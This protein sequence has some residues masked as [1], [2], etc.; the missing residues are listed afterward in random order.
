MADNNANEQKRNIYSFSPF[1]YEGAL[2]TVETDLRRGIPAV[3]IVGLA[4]GAVKEARERV[5][6]AFRN[7]GFEF[8][9]ERVLMSLSPADLKKEGASFDLAMAV[10]ILNEQNNYQGEPVLVLGE[11]E[12]SGNVRPVRAVHAAVESAVAAGITNVIVPAANVEEALAVPGSKVRGVSSLSEA[13]T[14]LKNNE[15]F[16]ETT[17]DNRF[18]KEVVFDEKLIDE[19][20]DVLESKYDG[21]SALDGHYDTA[22]AIE[23]AIAGKHNLLLTGSPGCGKT[24]L[25]QHLIPALTPKLTNEESQS[26]TRIWSLAGLM[27]PSDGIKKDAPFRMPHQTA[28]IEGICG[29]GPNCR[30][31][32]ISLAHNGVLFLD[33]A[34]EF[35]SSVLQML[36]VPVESKQITLSRAGRVTSYPSNF[37]LVMATNPCPCGCLGS[38]DKICL[39]SEKSIDL[40]WKKFSAPLLDR[41]E[42]RQY[43]ER[44]ENDTR[45]IT[46]NEMRK[47][48]ENAFRIQR[49]NP[50]YNSNLSPEEIAE[51]CKLN[52]ECQSFID[53]K[54][55]ISPRGKANTLKVALT[56]ANMDNRREIAIDD[57]K[58]AFNLNHNIQD[59][60]MG[61]E[62]AKTEE[63]YAKNEELYG[64][65]IEPVKLNS[66]TIDLTGKNEQQQSAVI[67]SEQLKENQQVATV[68][69]LVEPTTITVNGKERNCP[70]GILKALE[71]AIKK[72]DGLIEEYNKLTDDYNILAD[73]YEKLVDQQQS[74]N[75]NKQTGYSD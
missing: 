13:H 54:D 63:R 8:P 16:N 10:S 21:H 30:P 36:R 28:S 40:Y 43:V 72:N 4:D 51:K 6:A 18:S 7:S 15:L 64:N 34:A 31:G 29:G 37:Q 12:L 70:E 62:Q 2:V 42:I 65:K 19:A 69:S 56:I 71:S 60:L 38:H 75:H 14:I 67:Q 3:D 39:D 74:K 9:Q 11:L 35:R 1:G 49:E 20:I 61:K 45:K 55:D 52:D 22:R 66:V 27:K 24:M 17:Q 46:V 23:I 44:N 53:S 68:Q 57:L 41:V 47:H 25:S 32:E 5:M 73:K 26:T 33:E 50:H 48:I 58:E 59:R